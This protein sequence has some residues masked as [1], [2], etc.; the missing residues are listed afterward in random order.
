MGDHMRAI[1]VADRGLQHAK[2]DKIVQ[3]AYLRGSLLHRDTTLD[4][5]V[6]FPAQ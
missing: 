5:T 6:L 2:D 3:L 4:P 1:K